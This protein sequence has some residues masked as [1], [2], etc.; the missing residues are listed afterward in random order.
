MEEFAKV[1]L[2]RPTIVDVRGATDLVAAA[3]VVQGRVG[4]LIDVRVAVVDPV[5]ARAVLMASAR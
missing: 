5:A 2:V 3:R 4:A 1:M